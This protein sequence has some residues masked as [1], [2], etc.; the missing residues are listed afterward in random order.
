MSDRPPT[1]KHD[2]KVARI[3]AARAV[4]I[5]VVSAISAAIT[6]HAHL[7]PWQT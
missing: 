1:N 7:F 2:V 4:I 6:A 5:A 3:K